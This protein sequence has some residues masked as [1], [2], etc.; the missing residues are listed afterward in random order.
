M[1]LNLKFIFK[2]ITSCLSKIILPGKRFFIFNFMMLLNINLITSCSS[3]KYGQGDLWDMAKRVDPNVEL[4]LP[5]DLKSGIQCVNY[6]DGCISGRMVRVRSVTLTVVEFESEQ[7]AKVAAYAIGQYYA[8]NWLLDD[9]A[10]EPVL[11][12]FVKKAFN[13]KKINNS[14]ELTQ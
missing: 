6:E 13:A 14:E 9:V 1:N 12:D 5:K 8:K 3:E 7:K 11:E 10:G 2:L 4:I